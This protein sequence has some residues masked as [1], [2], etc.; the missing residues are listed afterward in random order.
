MNRSAKK[1]QRA[2][3]MAGGTGGH[4]F[5]ALAVAKILRQR[6]WH[7]EWLGTENGIESRIVP[8]NDFILHCITAVGLR[9]KESKKLL[10]APLH[11]LRAQWQS[12]K[13]FMRFRPDVVL[14]MGGFASGPG[15]LSAFLMRV[16]MVIHE[17]NAIAGTTNRILAKLAARTLSAFPS[18]FPRGETVGNPV[19]DE[20]A[21]LAF[22]KK[23]ISFPDEPLHLLVLGGSQGAQA[24]NNLLPAALALLPENIRP[25]V[26]HQAGSNLLEETRKHYQAMNVT[27]RVEPFI[28]DMASMYRWADLAVCRAGAMTVSELTCAQLP[29]LLIPLPSAIDDHQTANAQWLVDAGAARLLPQ[30]TLNVEKLA[31]ILRELIEN[32]NKLQDVSRIMKS[33]AKPESTNI[34]ADICEI[35]A[36]KSDSKREDKRHA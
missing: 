25:D 36:V 2:L 6:G 12:L 29:A 33:L 13:I 31:G 19:R 4:V 20:I 15:G 9:G 10:V 14:G 1:K 21:A 24:L 32:R 26:F 28:E 16:P 17:Q 8:A 22:A 18:V 30:A 34:V 5:P 11:L 3:I 27:A 23:V 35:S 7:V